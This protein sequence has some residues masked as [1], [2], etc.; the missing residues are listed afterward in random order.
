MRDFKVLPAGV[1]NESA[2]KRWRPAPLT[3]PDTGMKTQGN[4]QGNSQDGKKCKCD[5]KGNCSCSP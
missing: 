3:N 2:Y 1:G 4:S 5:G